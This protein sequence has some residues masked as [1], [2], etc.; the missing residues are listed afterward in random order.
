METVEEIYESMMDTY[1]TH[2][3]VRPTVSCDMSVRLYAVASQIFALQAQREWVQRQC[4]PQTAS[5]DF[6]DYHGEMRGVT[7]KEPCKAT[8][9]LRF[10]AST[11]P[12]QDLEIPKGT[13]AMTAGLLRYETVEAAVISAGETMVTVKAEAQEEGVG[14]NITA[15]MVITMSVPPVGV[16]ACTNLEPFENG[17]D[18][19][20][21]EEFRLRIMDTYQ[22]LPNGANAAFYLQEAMSIELVASAQVIPRSRGVCTVDVII[23]DPSG[24]PD[25]ELLAEV[26]AHLDERREIAVDVLVR[27]PTL[28]TM[29]LEVA[30]VSESEY[31][32]E[33]AI[34]EVEEVIGAWFDGSRL[35]ETLLEGALGHL[36]YQCKSVKNYQIETDLFQY[37]IAAA[38]LPVLGALT[39]RELT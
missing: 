25:E 37:T 3:G 23:S 36:I 24:E 8:G 39:V 21:D 10:L 13:I 16:S 1:A 35:G 33:E 29:D 38:E 6:L 34:A 28:V 7:R 4:F 15:G 9:T 17:T 31:T 12:T 26:Q 20:S 11:A 18:L 19:E 14:G 27:A 30:V 22:R 2:T 32:T 5:D